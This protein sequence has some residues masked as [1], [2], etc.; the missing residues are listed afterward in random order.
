MTND[1]DGQSLGAL[2]PF[3][4]AMAAIIALSNVLVQYPVQATVGGVDLADTLTWGAF[5]YPVAF[6]VT[7]LA[8]RRLGARPARRVVLVGC[9]LAVVLSVALASPRIAIASGT[10]FL[11]AHMLDVSVFDRL[12]RGAWWRPPLVSSGLGSLLD[13]LLFF[14]LAFAPVFAAL[15]FGGEEGSLGFPAPLLGVGPEV[16]LWVSLAL[17][18]LLVKALVALALLGPYGLLR[19]RDAVAA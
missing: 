19:G 6:L 10:A 4:A 11:A 7:D 15:D 5:T 9:A 16:P 14:S 13:T 3:V 18:D 2:A 17:G 1:R 12:R 8:N